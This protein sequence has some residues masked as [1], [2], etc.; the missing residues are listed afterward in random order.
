MRKILL[1]LLCSILFIG[2]G[3]TAATEES[4]ADEPVT[5]EKEETANYRIY[6]ISFDL[7]ASWT[8]IDLEYDNIYAFS[9]GDKD[10]IVT[11]G[12]PFET[13]YGEH[14]S[15]EV[16]KT[17]I[18]IEFENRKLLTDPDITYDTLLNGNVFGWSNSLDSE[19]NY[20]IEVFANDGHILEY[21]YSGPLSDSDSFSKCV[22]SIYHSMET[23]EYVD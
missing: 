19:N 13:D 12:S 1:I 10:V 16:I 7:P 15:E 9:T 4:A 21:V 2:C 6:D 22:N 17:L 11:V 5:P 14:T 3:Q 8:K 20:I 18:E 23:I